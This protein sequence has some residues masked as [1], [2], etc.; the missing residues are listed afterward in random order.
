MSTDFFERKASIRFSPEL[1]PILFSH[2][3]GRIRPENFF[4]HL[5]DHI[6]LYV[7][8]EG[9]ADYIVEDHYIP[10]SHGD[11]VVILP[12][13]VHVAVIKSPCVYERFYMLFPTKTLAAFP[14]DPTAYFSSLLHHKISL[15]EEKRSEFL[16]LL[17]RLSEL[18][19]KK[20]LPHTALTGMG[21]LL[22]LQG[23]LQEEGAQS[24]APFEPSL[25]PMLPD[26]LRDILKYVNLHAEEIVSVDAIAKH[27]YLSPQYLSAFFKK[28]VGVNLNE[29]LRIKKIALGRGHLEKGSS[30]AEA[31]YACGFSDSSHFI[32]CFKKYVGMTPKQYKDAFLKKNR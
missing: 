7:Y 8:I 25:P 24:D 9:D 2:E 20:N 12:H 27:F 32:K 29:Y 15:S 16:R 6:E 13:E 21:L 31:C 19:G 17:Y 30:V 22:E 23:L 26:H 1:P 4:L 10:L 28:H 3:R 11:A 18:C 14:L 5:N